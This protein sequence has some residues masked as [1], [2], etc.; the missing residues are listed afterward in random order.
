MPAPGLFLLATGCA[1]FPGERDSLLRLSATEFNAIGTGWRALEARGEYMS[2]ARL[3]EA[4]VERRANALSE[5]EVVLLHFHAAQQLAFAGDHARALSHL[6][7]ARYASEPLA[8][9]RWNDYVSATEAFLKRDRPAL[10][11]AREQIAGAPKWK[12]EI[13]TLNVV[14]AL[15][16]H[17]DEPYLAAYMR[18]P[19]AR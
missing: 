7:K 6:P 4:Y 10:R 15:L 3:L 9:L 1:Q 17:F 12:G 13:L 18:A 14:D 5:D 11:H 16:E 8:V 2:A 19:Q